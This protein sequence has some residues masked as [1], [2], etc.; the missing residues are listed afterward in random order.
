MRF[1]FGRN[2]QAFAANAL[3]EDRIRPARRDFHRLLS[4]EDLEGRTFY[5][6]GFGQGLALH[7]AAEAGAIVHGM[8][9]GNMQGATERTR[10]C[11]LSSALQRSN[12]RVSAKCG[13]ISQYL[14]TRSGNNSSTWRSDIP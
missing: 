4:P 7:L 6:I 2:W 8:D 14:T 13:Y 10:H 9:E 3:S 1:E 11:L 12:T 5:D